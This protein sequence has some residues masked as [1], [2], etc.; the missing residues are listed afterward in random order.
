MAEFAENALQ[1]VAVNGNFLLTDATVPYSF[2]YGSVM[3][4]DGSGL[5]TLRGNSRNRFSAYRVTYSSNIAIPADGT[6]EPI[7][8]AIGLNGETLATSTAIV[9]P[10]AVSNFWHVSDTTDILVPNG[11]CV[12]ISLKNIS[13]QAIE[14]QNTNLT[15]ERLA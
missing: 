10:A 1:R 6:V 5:I 12:Q 9:T 7:S 13:T 8:V 15:V 4:R 11:C 3:H 14:A 2:P